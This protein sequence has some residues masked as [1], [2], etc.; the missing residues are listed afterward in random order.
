M[1]D[2]WAALIKAARPAQD[3]DSETTIWELSERERD[4]IRRLSEKEGAID[5]PLEAEGKE[6]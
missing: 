1:V 4:I 5:E 2:K 3:I 6:A